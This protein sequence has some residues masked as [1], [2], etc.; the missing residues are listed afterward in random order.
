MKTGYLIEMDKS[1]EIKWERRGDGDGPVADVLC[2][3]QGRRGS[4][5]KF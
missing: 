5:G 4:F 2:A 1:L 3:V